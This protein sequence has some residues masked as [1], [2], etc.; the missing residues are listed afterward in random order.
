VQVAI[1]SL[2]FLGDGSDPTMRFSTALLIRVP[3]TQ[4]HPV[5]VQANSA[6]SMAH[7][8]TLYSACILFIILGT[9]SIVFHR[10]MAGVLA[11]RF[12]RNPFRATVGVQASDIQYWRS[13]LLQVGIFADCLC[14]LIVA[15]TSLNPQGFN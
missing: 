8:L 12:P 4:L 13:R 9:L 15:L 3:A 7:A 11:R 6:T 10:R 14:I 1:L 2:Y 5:T